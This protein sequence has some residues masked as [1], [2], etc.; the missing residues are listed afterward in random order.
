MHNCI[1]KQDPVGPSQNG[2]SL[3][4]HPAASP[5][6]FLCGNTLNG[7]REMRK[8]RKETFEQDKRIVRPFKSRTFSCSSRAADGILS[9]VH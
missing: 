2:A 9:H 6:C 3:P 7:I 5:P 1:T 8:R 4:A